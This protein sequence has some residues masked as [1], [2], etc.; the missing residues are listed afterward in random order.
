MPMKMLSGAGNA[1]G[2]SDPSGP[3]RVRTARGEAGANA[4]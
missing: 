4:G 1:A 3:G 2:T